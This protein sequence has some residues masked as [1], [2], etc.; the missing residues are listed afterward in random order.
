MKRQPSSAAANR[1]KVQ[2]LGRWAKYRYISLLRAK[3]GSSKVARGFSIGLA[4]EMFTLPTFGLAAI[5]ILPLVYL[6]RASL[7]GALIG[8]LFGKLIYIP[9]A[10][11]NKSVGA[12]VVPDSW[13]QHLGFFPSWL[14]SI[15][16]GAL[17]LIIGG[18]IDG[19]LLGLIAFFPIWLLLQWF[20]SK[21]LERRRKLKAS[22]VALN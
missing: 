18:M 16:K 4:I 7:P 1:S 13:S 19:A 5:L 21:R 14:E 17:D 11:V 2:R 10:F 6:F 22:R 15:I 20:A 3:G 12:W 9:M 8:F